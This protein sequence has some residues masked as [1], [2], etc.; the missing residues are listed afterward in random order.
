MRRYVGIVSRVARR[1]TDDGLSGLDSVFERLVKAA[2]APAAAYD[3]SALIVG[4]L[5][6]Q[7]C[8]GR[9]P[10]AG[11]DELERND[12]EVPVDPGDAHAIIAERADGSGAMCAVFVI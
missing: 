8:S 6:R 12:L 10:A 4:I 2:P 7:D 11:A 9:V 5:H 3:L 1:A